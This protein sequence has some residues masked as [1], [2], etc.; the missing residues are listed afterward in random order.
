MESKFGFMVE[1]NENTLQ[2]VGKD[3]TV[4][5]KVIVSCNNGIYTPINYDKVVRLEKN[6]V[7]NASK[8]N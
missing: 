6:M 4:D 5:H 3:V 1:K 7:R 8:F 2:I